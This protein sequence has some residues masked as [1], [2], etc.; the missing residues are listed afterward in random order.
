MKPIAPRASHQCKDLIILTLKHW[1]QLHEPGYWKEVAVLLCKTGEMNK[2]L[3][4]KTASR[5]IT[6]IKART[7]E[8]PLKLKH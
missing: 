3:G 2:N 4:R 6:N 7:K 8:K 1:D 5:H